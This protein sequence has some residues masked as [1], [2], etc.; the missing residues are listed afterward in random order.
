MAEVTKPGAQPRPRIRFG[1]FMPPMHPTNEDPTLAIHRDLELMEYLDELGYV[2]PRIN[3]VNL[4]REESEGF[5][6]ANH[7]RF[8]ASMKAAVG[9]K[10]DQYIAEKGG[11][12][13]A[14]VFQEVF[15][16]QK[17]ETN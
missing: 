8:A 15:A 13:V 16:N 7:Q 14:P 9:A 10:I 6:R 5:L 11:D 4:N 3:R 17:P 12:N 2:A 1:V